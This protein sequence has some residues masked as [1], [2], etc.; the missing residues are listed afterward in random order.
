MYSE[1][2]DD[3]YQD[4]EDYDDDYDDDV[5]FDTS[6]ATG[7]VASNSADPTP[8]SMRENSM[9]AFTSGFVFE[10]GNDVVNQL[11]VGATLEVSGDGELTIV[12]VPEPTYNAGDYFSSKYGDAT[13]VKMTSQF[14]KVKSIVNGTA[15]GFLY[16]ADGSNV[17]RGQ[18]L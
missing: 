14:E 17:V 3:Y 1:Y 16:V 9:S 10:T 2:D 12:S 8:S 6:V 11:P 13:I 15:K 5:D 4:Y 18:L 7:A